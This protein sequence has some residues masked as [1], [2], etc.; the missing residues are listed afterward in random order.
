MDDIT[1]RALVSDPET[2]R[3]LQLDALSAILPMERRDRLAELLTDD[4]V[5][6]L[7]HLAQEGM[8]ENSLRA[9]ASD[10]AYL[11][12]W[13]QA[14]IGA[15]LPWPASE[16]LVLKFV[17]HHL[18]DPA[19]RETDPQHGMPSDVAA[20][21]RES[22]ML[23]ST[24]PHAP[25]TVRRLASWGTLHRWKGQEGPFASPSLRSALRLAVRAGTRP[26]QRKSKRAV[27]RD[28]LDRLL[29]TCRSDRLADTRDLA[30]LLLAFASGGRR[31]SEVA[32][33]RVEQISD[34]PA[35]PLDP[36]NP[37][38]PTLA[39]MSIQLGRTKA[40]MADEARRVLLVGPP[41]EALREWLERA[42]ISK[43]PIFRAIDRWEAIEE[44]ALTPQS[45]NL[46]VKRRC[47][48]AGLEAREFSAHGLRSGYLTEAA[49][50]GVSLP[51]A[52]QQ[53]QHRSVQ[54]AASYYNEADR[55]LGQAA[56]LGV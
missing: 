18:W 5:A 4:D 50:R 38:S 31:R 6:T 44:R 52:M 2:R 12:A 40:G 16:S 30:I 17:A 23:R 13:A 54:Q 39:C 43:G 7:K 55:R 42:D 27:T 36:K 29:A 8:G 21:L 37:Q 49:Q 28:V 41:V 51:E 24:G 15:A 11:E 48:L 53:S 9:L 1:S 34:E 3:A 33:L 22:E 10:L 26:R 56:R 46:I 45:I 35:V 25:S 47:A 20:A 14:A 32:R 19:K